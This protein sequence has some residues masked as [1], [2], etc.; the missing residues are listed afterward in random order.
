M[1]L[2]FALSLVTL[3]VAKIIQNVMLG[4]ILQQFTTPNVPHPVL[5]SDF[6]T[7]ESATAG[8]TGVNIFGEPWGCVQGLCPPP[9]PSDYDYPG[10]RFRSLPP[11]PPPPPP[12]IRLPC[13]K[14]PLLPAKNLE[15]RSILTQLLHGKTIRHVNCWNTLPNVRCSG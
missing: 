12:P 10:A 4:N 3:H 13:P 2:E 15:P 7:R 9:S 14:P 11:P 5:C 6:T 8:Y 1:S